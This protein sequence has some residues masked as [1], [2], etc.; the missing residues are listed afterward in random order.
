MVI[1]LQLLAPI[2]RVAVVLPLRI[3]RIDHDL[4]RAL[5][6][7]PAERTAL[8]LR[9]HLPGRQA[10]CAQQ[11]A[12]RLDANVLVVLCTD[13]AQLEGASHLAVKLVLLLR[14]GDMILERTLHGKR[15][16]RVVWLAVGVQV[17][18]FPMAV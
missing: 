7:R 12:A 2:G 1:V 16:V 15:E 14:H 3:E 17:E 6:F 9:V 10:W 18:P 11:M 4:F 13:F 5:D 8:S